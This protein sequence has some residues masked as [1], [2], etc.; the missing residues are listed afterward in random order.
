MVTLGTVSIILYHLRATKKKTDFVKLS[1]LNENKRIVTKILVKNTSIKKIVLEA[2]V[3][4]KLDFEID[5]MKKVIEKYNDQTVMK[6]FSN[7][8]KKYD[9]MCELFYY[10]YEDVMIDLNMTNMHET[11]S[12]MKL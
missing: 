12:W 8:V 6:F 2:I 5:K 10:V 9:R 11:A 3:K 1:N 4:H 7:M